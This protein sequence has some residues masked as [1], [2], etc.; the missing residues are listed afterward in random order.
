M[1]PESLSA[2]TPYARPDADAQLQLIGFPYA[3]GSAGIFRAWEA[4][5]P[6]WVAL[7]AVE[8][9]GHGTRL[10][11]RPF[12]NIVLLANAVVRALRPLWEHPF[13][14]FGYSVGSLLAFEV[15]RLLR[16]QGLPAPVHLLCA[17]Y[18]APTLPASG[19]PLHT[20]A[21]PELI[22]ELRRLGGTPEEVLS[23]DEL[24]DVLL[25]TLRADFTLDETYAYTAAPPLDCPITVFGGLRDTRAPRH[26]LSDWSAQTRQRFRLRLCPGDHFF[27]NSARSV[28]L[29]G[30]TE[31][32]E[33]H[34]RSLT[35]SGGTP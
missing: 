5:L 8:T 7:R 24:L 28:L 10:R 6:S 11:E 29:R 15:A 19:E 33:P 13:A 25:P 1:T 20:L 18:R 32:L 34:V 9:P 30:V 2:W 16:Q 31:E 35:P 17:A 4:E 12:T 3:G 23:C 27:L 22:A 21:R 14:L 26:V